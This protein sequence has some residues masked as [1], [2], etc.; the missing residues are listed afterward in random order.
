MAPNI[1]LQQRKAIFVIGGVL[2]I[3]EDVHDID[4]DLNI[5]IQTL[6]NQKL[7]EYQDMRQLYF[8]TVNNLIEQCKMDPHRPNSTL[9]IF[10]WLLDAVIEERYAPYF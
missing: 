9:D 10:Y 5:G 4:E 2:Q 1:T 8:G 3:L 7:I 6:C